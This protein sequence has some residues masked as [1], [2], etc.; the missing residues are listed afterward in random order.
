MAHQQVG[1]GDV[2]GRVAGGGVGPVDDHRRAGWTDDVEGV[3]IAVAEAGT[4]GQ[5]GQT[6]EQGVAQ[7]RIEAGCVPEAGGEPWFQR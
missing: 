1:A 2:G 6:G 5:L 7:C 3:E 4:L